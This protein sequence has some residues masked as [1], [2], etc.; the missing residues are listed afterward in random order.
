MQD[1]EQ[2]LHEKGRGE[3]ELIDTRAYLRYR[4]GQYDAALGDMQT[5]IRLME[6]RRM[7]YQFGWD[8]EL[9]RISPD[10][11]R[12]IRREIEI[13]DE[14]LGV[15]Y[16]HRGEIYQQL[17]AD[18]KLADAQ[19]SDYRAKANADLQHALRLNYNPKNGVL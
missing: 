15:M 18:A 1:I 8:P 14:D 7:K 17:A 2:A 19:R 4:L 5:A 13:F 11:R 12:E 10:D 6:Q 9:A 16:H 3:P